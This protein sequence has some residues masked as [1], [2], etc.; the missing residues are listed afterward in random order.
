MAHVVLGN[1]SIGETGEKWAIILKP[2]SEIFIKSTFTM[3]RKNTVP[4]R[5]TNIYVAFAVSHYTYKLE[6]F[7]LFQRIQKVVFGVNWD[8]PRRTGT[9][10]KEN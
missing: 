10:G 3:T 8:R 1:A 5:K 7:P 2:F 6:I 4:M 9:N